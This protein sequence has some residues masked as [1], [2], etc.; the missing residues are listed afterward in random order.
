MIIPVIV[1]IGGNLSRMVRN[2]DK[3]T[4]IRK[5]S[6]QIHYFNSLRVIFSP[7]AVAFWPINVSGAR[8]S[9][10]AYRVVDIC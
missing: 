4:K 8:N 10:P 3:K 7:N 2:L 1:V 9:H 6:I 5:K